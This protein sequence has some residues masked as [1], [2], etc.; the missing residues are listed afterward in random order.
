MSLTMP[1]GDILET[2]PGY[3][4]EEINYDDIEVEEVGSGYFY[5]LLRSSTLKER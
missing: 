5:A 2:P 3:P 4:F 1:S